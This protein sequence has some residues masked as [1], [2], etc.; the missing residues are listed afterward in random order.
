M[1]KQGYSVDKSEVTVA[2]MAGGKSTRM[3][4]DKA[5]VRFHDKPMVQHVLE[6]VEGLGDETILIANE[7]EKYRHLGLPIFGDIYVNCGPLGGLHTAL[8]HAQFPYVLVVACDMPWLN[9]QLLAFM[10]SLRHTADAIVPRWNKF[11]EPLHAVYGNQC[12]G[13]IEANLQAKNLKLVSFYAQVNVRYLDQTAISAFDP[14][15]R[16]FS[17]VNTPEDL[18]SAASQAG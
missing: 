10:L 9:P 14:E 8:F 17:N 16:S 18:N 4:T 1:S 2:I 15:G 6:R 11:P 13:P 12:L 3:G 7:P 5:F